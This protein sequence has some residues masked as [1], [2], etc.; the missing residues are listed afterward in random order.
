M[1]DSFGRDMDIA[2][3]F[4]EEEWDTIADILSSEGRDEMAGKIRKWV[5][6]RV[7]QNEEDLEAQK[8]PHYWDGLSG[9]QGG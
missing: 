2:I 3:N 4:I 8:D 7:K 1:K 6:M 9:A 5:A